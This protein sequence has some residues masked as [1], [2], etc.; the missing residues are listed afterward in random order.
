MSLSF[1][2]Y[3]VLVSLLGSPV[4]AVD[5]EIQSRRQEIDLDDPRPPQ[6]RGKEGYNDYV[7]NHI[8]NYVAQTGEDITLRYLY[9]AADVQ[10]AAADHHYSLLPMTELWVDLANNVSQTEANKIEETTRGQA[11][12]ARWNSEREWR[13]TASWFGTVCKV[14]KRRNKDKLCSSMLY[15]KPISTP[16][17]RHGRR[18]ESVAIKQFT[19][20]CGVHVRRAGLHINPR[21]P[22]LGASPDGIIDKDTIVEVKCPYTGR[23]SVI[24]TGRHFKFLE[25]VCGELR[26]KQS[27]HY[28]DQIQ[29]QMLITGAQLCYLVIYTF[30]DMKVVKVNVDRDYCYQALL[31]KLECFYKSVFR[32]YVAQSLGTR[33]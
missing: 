7:R 24:A 1:S 17:I 33:Y 13:L 14:T 5:L 28:F 32:K 30:K 19:D 12:V 22:F 27:H 25:N 3:L 26:L 29:G 18:F 4:K 2:N 21:F 31:P 9:P 20:T 8:I 23:D 15:P 6:Y 11:S 16:A 10:A